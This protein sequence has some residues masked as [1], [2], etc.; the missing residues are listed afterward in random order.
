MEKGTMK[1]MHRS[2]IR[3]A[4]SLA[5]T[6][7]GA[8]A[9]AGAR[10]IA[11][12]VA[13]VAVLLSALAACVSAPKRSATM[14]VIPGVETTISEVRTRVR[15]LAGRF[16]GL[17]EETAD[18][19]IASS[20]DVAVRREA[21]L[22][23]TNAIPLLQESLFRPDP[24]EALFDAWGLVAQ[25]QE[26]L[27]T[28]GIWQ[29]SATFQSLFAETF[30]QMETELE[31]VFRKVAPTAD[32]AAVRG[33][34]HAWAAKH[35]LGNT[36]AS[37]TSSRALVADTV[38]ETGISGLQALAALPETLDDAMTRVDTYSRF[39]PKQARWQAEL[40]VGDLVTGPEMRGTLDELA[41]V[42]GSVERISKVVEQ[43]P[44]LATSERE[45]MLRAVTAERI[46]T[47]EA[48][49][50]E[51]LETLAFADGQRELITKDLGAGREALIEE[52]RKKLVPDVEA[53]RE[54]LVK[55]AADRFELI[56]NRAI[57]LGAMVLAAFGLGGF[58][59]G[60]VLIHFVRRPPGRGQGPPGS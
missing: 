40:L 31:E 56:V 48:I 4:L 44:G 14:N 60:F 16:S 55:D 39:M 54:N 59:A 6:T 38:K 32:V 28:Q 58:A 11:P 15:G 43:L 27:G 45:A 18:Q 33:R 36:L 9:W 10:G 1:P 47:L 26:R 25:M 41:Y 20:T 13:F 8:R 52:L 2:V 42:S 5:M 57:A 21:L 29:R 37:R 50:R 22:T 7:T 30:Q 3:A 34:V 19:A 53:M 46:A 23:K 49:H 51:R 12:A 35:P 17:L 24:L